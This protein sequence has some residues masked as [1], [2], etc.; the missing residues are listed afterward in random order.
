MAVNLGH[1][2]ACDVRESVYS[3]RLAFLL[4]LVV[5][6]AAAAVAVGVR[7]PPPAP[8][9]AGPPPSFCF[10][11]PSL[12]AS[13]FPGDRRPAVLR[14]RG[15]RRRGPVIHYPAVHGSQHTI[16]DAHRDREST[17]THIPPKDDVVGGGMMA[18]RAACN[19]R[20]RDPPEGLCLLRMN[21]VKEEEEEEEGSEKT[22][23]SG[24][25]GSWSCVW[26]PGGLPVSTHHHHHIQD[27]PT[28]AAASLRSAQR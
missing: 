14:G 11:M 26:R 16:Q 23:A 22:A 18:S 12:A 17:E 3:R 28:A 2:M 24:L 13:S 15:G 4:F 9:P 1:G 20:R 10:M 21:W 25:M 7:P 27:S 8:A 6:L 19:S 5:A